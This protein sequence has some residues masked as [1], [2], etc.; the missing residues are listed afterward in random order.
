[1]IVPEDGAGM[2][3]WRITS[4][5]YGLFKAGFWFMCFFLLVGFISMISVVYLSARLRYYKQFNQQLVEATAILDDIAL[6]LDQYEEQESKLRTI[7]GEDLDLPEPLAVETGSPGDRIQADSAGGG[8][9]ELERAIADEERRLRSLPTMWPVAAWQ[10]SEGFTNNGDPRTD[11]HG[12]DLLARNKTGVVASADGTV[13][14]VEIDKRYGQMLIIDHGNGWQTKYG[15]LESV[16]V[17]PGTFVA[18]G[19]LIAVFGGTGGTSTGPHLHFGMF[20]KGQPVD[21]LIWLE[22]RPVMNLADSEN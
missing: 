15:H 17:K 3:K 19:N 16:L 12:I 4:R 2:R 18:K 7:L 5:R 20:Y 13:I 9:V 1:M 22:D 14:A 11:H 21:P 10:I 8:V 6:R